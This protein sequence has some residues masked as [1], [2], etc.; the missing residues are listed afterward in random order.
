[1]KSGK[2]PRKYKNFDTGRSGFFGE[3]QIV[4]GNVTKVKAAIFHFDAVD[5][6]CHLTLELSGGAAVRLERAVR[7]HYRDCV[8]RLHSKLVKPLTFLAKFQH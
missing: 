7:R 5:F 8:A 6:I 1:M 2:K 4:S 3:S